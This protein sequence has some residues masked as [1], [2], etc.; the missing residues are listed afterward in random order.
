MFYSKQL[1]TETWLRETEVITAPI[2]KEYWE[3]E[4]GPISDS[5]I[6][7][8]LAQLT[9]KGKL[10][11]IGTGEYRYVTENTI[12][13]FSIVIQS[14]ILDRAVW[15]ALGYKPF[16]KVCV[17]ETSIINN[18]SVHV[19]AVNFGVIEV[20]KELLELVYNH[21]NSSDYF[22]GKVFL[23]ID[24]PNFQR[25]GRNKDIEKRPILLKRMVGASPLQKNEEGYYHPKIEKLI[26]DLIVEQQNFQAYSGADLKS[27]LTHFYKSHPI[28]EDTLNSYA[29]YRNASIEVNDIIEHTLRNDR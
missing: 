19:P 13:S 20:E 7:G 17:W 9:Q 5:T 2:F 8:K 24:N 29:K 11:R 4:F 3:R 18:Y 25:L 15:Y 27:I 22:G 14:K 12:T 28:N 1:N 6:R 10:R 21:L 26:V 23:D 16:I